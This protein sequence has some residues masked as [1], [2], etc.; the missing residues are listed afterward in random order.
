MNFPSSFFIAEFALCQSSQAS[1]SSASP[2]N[3]EASQCAPSF[4]V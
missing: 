1:S 3:A 4:K 2:A